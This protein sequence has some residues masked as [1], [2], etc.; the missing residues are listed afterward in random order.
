MNGCSGGGG[1]KS[2][3]G[4]NM[5]LKSATQQGAAKELANLVNQGKIS[6]TQAAPI[7]ANEIV[8]KKKASSH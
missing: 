5:T 1:G 4:G 6:N 7:A 2:G 8:S 3:S